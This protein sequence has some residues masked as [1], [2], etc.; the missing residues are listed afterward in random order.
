MLLDKFI[1]RADFSSY[2]DFLDNFKIIVPPYF[3]FA[4]DVVDEIASIE[5]KKVALVWCDEKGDERI[6]TFEDIK[7][8]SS[9]AAHF[10]RSCGIK[11]G[12]RILLV[13]K[14][15][16]E[17][18]FCLLGLHRIGAVCV[19]ASQMLT[20]KDIMY[21]NNAAEIKM[22]VAVNDPEI[23]QHVE[24]AQAGSPTMQHKVLIGGK[25]NGWIDANFDTA[26]A[27][28][29]YERPTGDDATDNQDCMLI[30]FTSG[31]TGLPK[32]V[33]HNFTY[34]LGH[35]V[36]AKYWQCVQN[37]KLH[38]TLAETGW[39][40]AMWGKIYG[41]WI[42]GAV[43]FAY[44]FDR[45][46]SKNLL[47]SISKYKVAT[48]CA[49]P[50]VYRLLF[51]EDFARYDLTSLECCSIAGE[52]YDRGV[53]EEFHKRTGLI[54]KEAY[55]QTET[56]VVLGNFPWMET[57]PCSM[58]K[59]APGY[60]TELLNEGGEPCKTGE[61][62]EVVIRIDDN[63]LPIGLFSGYYRDPEYTA[64]MWHDGFYHTGDIAW[65][66]D[67]GYYWFAG[68]ADNMIKSS[69]YRIGPFEVESVLRE[70]PAVRECVVTG[71]PDLDR[72][73]AVKAT[74]VLNDKYEPSKQLIKELQD[75]VKIITA[76]YKY[77]RFIEFA[78][79]IP[80]TNSG[81]IKHSKDT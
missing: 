33:S 31:T 60:L 15:R 41:Q 20:A 80:K 38:L 75:Y 9:R 68:R 28:D 78:E 8:Y 30:Y 14:R 74:I 40:K 62:G 49:P 5:P 23:I 66:D 64:S 81:K 17:F 39:A 18:W 21:R 7:K 13:L 37:D 57:K 1:S 43:V 79:M 55:G 16:Y 36:T 34:P 12:D 50:T 29:Y 32:M 46:S 10:F 67:D 69:G 58:G 26:G 11:K 44:D 6:F 4:Y 59:P 77:P 48:F 65:K 56:T 47:H 3:N 35:I 24:E 61:K 51:E 45:F 76:P 42:C 63:K 70:H 19:P 52:A 54:L 72:G 53:A 27:Q 22:I 25:R 71:V 2:E 73:Q